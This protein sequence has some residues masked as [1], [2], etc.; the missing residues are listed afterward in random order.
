MTSNVTTVVL[1]WDGLDYELL[2]EYGLASAFGAYHDELETFANPLIGEP[3]TRE[4]WPSMITGEMPETHGIK[5]A[6]EDEGVQWSNPTIRTAARVAQYT[7]PDSVR[8]VLGRKL[9]SRGAEVEKYGAEYY[10]DRDL[11]T[12]FDDRQSLPIAIPNYRTDLDDRFEFMFDRGAEL[13]RF[14]DRDAEGWRPADP[15]QQAAVEQEMAAEEGRKLALIENALDRNYDLIFAWFGWVDTAGHVDPVVENPYQ[16]RAYEQAAEW[17][18]QIRAQ[19]CDDDRLICVSDHGLQNG[20]HTHHAT[21]ASD[22]SVAVD[23]ADHVTDLYEAIDILTPR[24]GDTSAPQ[25]TTDTGD[26]QEMTAGAAD[27]VHD[28]LTNLGYI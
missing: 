9:R 15:D 16:R 23:A 2:Q 10:A 13:S 21:I 4:L 3:H 20:S 24:S 28:R 22:T 8:T 17:T 5:A 12:V 1:G 19:L 6:T 7:I 18:Q 14:L 11:E 26:D 25:L 27:D